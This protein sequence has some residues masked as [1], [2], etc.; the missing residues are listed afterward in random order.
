[1]SRLSLQDIDELARLQATILNR[2]A[3]IDQLLERE[4][5]QGKSDEAPDGSVGKIAMRNA[6]GRLLDDITEAARGM[7]AIVSR[8]DGGGTT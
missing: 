1:M 4:K 6:L 2:S 5:R 3:L 8:D 7:A